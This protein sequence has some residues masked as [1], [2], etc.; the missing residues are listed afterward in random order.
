MTLVIESFGT[1][2]SAFLSKVIRAAQPHNR[3]PWYCSLPEKYRASISYGTIQQCV[4][5][6]ADKFLL[7]DF[8]QGATSRCATSS[9]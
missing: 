9:P 8:I 4:G 3:K 7:D 1:S 2:R 5:T 6:A